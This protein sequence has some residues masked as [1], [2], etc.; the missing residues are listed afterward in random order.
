MSSLKEVLFNN[1]TFVIL[2]KRLRVGRS[3]IWLRSCLSVRSHKRDVCSKRDHMEPR[4]PA[5]Q[6][7]IYNF[8]YVLMCSDNWTWNAGLFV[9]NG[10]LSGAPDGRG[11]TVPLRCR[12]APEVSD[13][14]WVFAAYSE[15]SSPGIERC[16]RAVRCCSRFF[17]VSVLG[18]LW[19]L[20]AEL[21]APAP[22]QFVFPLL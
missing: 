3:F 8:S 14:N 18:D 12:A 1:S 16:G 13:L 22:G 4:S 5:P 2:T 11:W 10:N 6:D 7:E 20:R 17:F 9:Q 15:V 21:T 19:S